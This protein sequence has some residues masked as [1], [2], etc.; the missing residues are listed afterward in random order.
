MPNMEDIVGN[1]V[2]DSAS[3][4]ED[5]PPIGDPSIGYY[6]GISNGMGHGHRDSHVYRGPLVTV[7][8]SHT[9][10]VE[11]DTASISV[12]VTAKDDITP[13]AA[14]RKASKIHA[15][16]LKRTVDA[17]D[18]LIIERSRFSVSPIMIYHRNLPPT[19]AGYQ[20]TFD[21]TFVTEKLAQV[22]HYL[23][24]I[25]KE[26][27][28]GIEVGGVRFSLRKPEVVQDIALG[29]ASGRAVAK[30]RVMMVGMGVTNRKFNVLEIK[31]S[32]VSRYRPRFM[33]ARS[34][35]QESARSAAPAVMKLDPGIIAITSTVT[36]TVELPM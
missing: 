30:A 27:S 5:N 28:T 36:L 21:V 11:P 32:G 19:H 2:G 31:E 18:G 25:L 13:A 6:H 24:D 26:P 29:K 10:R 7:E 20:A 17:H 8:G 33:S 34:I 35:H 12:S 9:E 22:A 3:S 1:T 4:I 16:L 23:S 15:S 14:S